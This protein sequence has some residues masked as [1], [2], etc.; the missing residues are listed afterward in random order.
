[1]SG[2]LKENCVKAQALGAETKKN[3]E[4]AAKADEEANTKV[5]EVKPPDT[6]KPGKKEKDPPAPKP[7]PEEPPAVAVVDPTPPPEQPVAVKTDPP[8]V[9][10]TGKGYAGFA[11]KREAVEKR[12]SEDPTLLKSVSGLE[13]LYRGY[14]EDVY[15]GES[16]Y[17]KLTAKRPQDRRLNEHLR[18]AELYEKADKKI[19]DLYGK[20][21]R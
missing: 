6:K 8:P 12:L 2:D 18:D 14:S 21:F 4:V 17:G 20:L 1:L 10:P 7:P 3:A 15:E 13:E 11:A 5:A 19:A 9:K 16:K